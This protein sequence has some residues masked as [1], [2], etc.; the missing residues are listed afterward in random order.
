MS[1][2]GRAPITIPAGVS[3]IL[4]G[5]RVTVKGPK[6]ELSHNLPRAIKAVFEDQILT[7]S[8]ASDSKTHR[9][10]HGLSRALVANMVEG[11]EQGYT[12][13]LELVGTGYRAKVSGR[14]LILSLGFSHDIDFQAPEGI[15]LNLEGTNLIHVE[16]HDKQLV[17]QTAANIRAFK[18]PEP[19]KGKGIRYQAEIVR[20]K[21]GKAAK[22]AA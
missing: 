1:K 4:E 17:G 10:L 13:T 15:T 19:Y 9:A 12:K 11:V 16:G 2:I 22:A 18:K 5:S 3:L 21:A 20:R 8:R 14:K 6:G 7:L